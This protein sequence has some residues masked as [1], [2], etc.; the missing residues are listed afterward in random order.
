[1]QL[2]LHP[3]GHMENLRWLRR[4]Q[5]ALGSDAGCAESNTSWAARWLNSLDI[6]RRLET[7]AIAYFQQGAD[8]GMG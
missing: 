4:P 6:D 3:F 1:M 2:Q 8:W 7:A 5:S